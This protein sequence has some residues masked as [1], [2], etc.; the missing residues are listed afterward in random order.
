MI[1]FK[2][3]LENT[4]YKSICF[5]KNKENKLEIIAEKAT[6]CGISLERIDFCLSINEAKKIVEFISTCVSEK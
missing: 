6:E 5:Q 4:E 3:K 1:Y 2:K